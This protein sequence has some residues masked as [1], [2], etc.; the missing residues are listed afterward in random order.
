MTKKEMFKWSVKIKKQVDIKNREKQ[1]NYD[2]VWVEC[3]RK[4]VGW[5]KR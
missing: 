2:M 3:I 4:K 1:I 5:I